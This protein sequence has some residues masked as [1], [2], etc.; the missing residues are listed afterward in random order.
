M[1]SVRARRELAILVFLGLLLLPSCLVRKRVVKAPGTNKRETRPLLTA[2]K[3]E[4]IQRI[5][6]VSDPI[7]S[8]TM[9]A[10]MSPSIGSLYGGQVTDYATITGYV[11]FLRPNDIRVIG[12][13]PVIHSTAFDMVSTGND[14]RVSIPLKNQFFVGQNDAPANSKN[15]LENLRPVAFL[16]ALLI[17]PPDPGTFTVFED[18]TNETRALYILMILQNEGGQLTLLR[19]VYFDR[20]TLQI[21]RQK[22]FDSKGYIVSDTRYGDWKP[23]SGILFP[24]DIDIQRPQDGYEVELR[25]LDMKVNA[26]E[27]TAAKFILNQPPGAHVRELSSTST[28][29]PGQPVPAPAAS[30]PAGPHIPVAAACCQDTRR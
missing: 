9:K 24:S 19:N 21:T 20:Y 8:F 17:R 28:L 27:V 23:Y 12:Q 10:D 18:D 5:H 16:N 29:K 7:V 13:D 4:L 14:F 6:A 25:V 22:T 30:A 26:G 3:E 11:L 15:K 1:H 2:T